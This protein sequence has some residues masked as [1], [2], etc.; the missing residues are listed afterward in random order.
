MMRN[1]CRIYFIFPIF[2]VLFSTIT[3]TGCCVLAKELQIQSLLASPESHLGEHVKVYGDIYTIDIPGGGVIGKSIVL[4]LS[5]PNTTSVEFL[6]CE[7]ARDKP[8]P[9]ELRE[10]QFVTICGKVDIIEAGTWLR[11]CK[12]LD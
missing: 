6:K 1:T 4:R 7:F 2:L 5:P 3:I 8:P 12:V 10:G 9:S 11:E